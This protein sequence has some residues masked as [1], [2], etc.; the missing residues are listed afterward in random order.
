MPAGRGTGR[1]T[2]WLPPRGKLAPVRTLVTDEGLY[3]FFRLCG[4]S[5]LTPTLIR[6]GFAVTPS[7]VGEGK[8]RRARD[9]AP[10]R[11]RP[12]GRTVRRQAQCLPPRGRWPK[13]GR[14]ASPA[15]TRHPPGRG[16]QG[17]SSGR[18][19]PTE[20][21]GGTGSLNP[22][23]SFYHVNKKSKGNF[24]RKLALFRRNKFVIDKQVSVMV[25]Y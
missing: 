3:F 16:G 17:G 21:D 15:A 24:Y 10:C 20:R 14:G 12:P 13:A 25:V 9:A 8:G 22:F 1:T 18:P 6:H 2:S 11:V 7:P 23:L 4:S 5:R 19:S